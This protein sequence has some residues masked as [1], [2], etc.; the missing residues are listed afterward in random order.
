VRGIHLSDVRA[1]FINLLKD[2][3][4]ATLSTSGLLLT[5]VLG[6]IVPSAHESAV[7]KN[8]A[9]AAAMFLIGSLF[10]VLSLSLLLFRGANPAKSNSIRHNDATFLA[11]LSLG[12]LFF[13]IAFLAL[14]VFGTPSH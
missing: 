1:N 9:G 3:D 2:I 6:F 10:S 14:A 13:G 12:C 11:I 4:I 7:L 8:A 5:L